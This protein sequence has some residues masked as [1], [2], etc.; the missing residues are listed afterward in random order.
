MNRRRVVELGTGVLA[1]A[2]VGVL[3]TRSRQQLRRRARRGLARVTRILRY[4]RGKLHGVWYRGTRGAPCAE[5]SDE[6][7]AERIRA[8]LGLV[9][10]QLDVP[11]VHV[12]VQQGN[13]TLT[14]RVGRHEDVVVIRDAVRGVPGVRGI[15]CLIRPG[16][17]PGDTRPSE[18]RAA[19]RPSKALTR[20]VR[21]TVAAGVPEPA[22]LEALEAVLDTF[23]RRLPEGERAHLLAH[24][25]Q[26][27]RRLVHPPW[28][29]A[30]TRV[31]SLEGFVT[32]IDAA[33]DLH[34]A[35]AL[36]TTSAVLTT[37]R[38]LVPE[39]AADITANLPAQLRVLWTDAAVTA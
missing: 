19:A 2:G 3:L 13:T 29:R 10:R 32:A 18:G 35:D 28:P 8:T 14:G 12:E 21:A 27:V 23:I 37:V 6:T 30:G 26:D 5:V 31:R 34:G 20:L 4:H 25:P 1:V 24:L 39:E 16:L 9:T 11:R 15:T 7:L 22:A 33:A 36:A 17:E 38:A